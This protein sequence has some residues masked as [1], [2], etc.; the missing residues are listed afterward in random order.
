MSFPLATIPLVQASPGATSDIAIPIINS[1]G[2]LD[3]T[4][5]NATM[6][7]TGTA[8]GKMIAELSATGFLDPSLFQGILASAGAGS[9]GKVPLLNSEGLLD[10]SFFAGI[11]GSSNWVQIGNFVIQVGTVTLPAP[12]SGMGITSAT[13]TFPEPM[14]NCLGCWAIYTQNTGIS[15]GN[16]GFPVYS[17]TSPSGTS[18]NIS[19]ISSQNDSDPNT[20]IP[21]AWIAIGNPVG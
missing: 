16:N 1:S 20:S 17:M 11:S 10:P 5:L 9:S 3:P 6:T 8:Q 13:V 19:A 12:P 14:A 15:P 7:S 4:L 18:V 21:T 2:F